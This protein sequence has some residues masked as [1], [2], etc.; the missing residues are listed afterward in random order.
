MAPLHRHAGPWQGPG[1][2][3]AGPPPMEIK[4]QRQALEQKRLSDMSFLSS[5]PAPSASHCDAAAFL[6]QL[7][8]GSNFSVVWQHAVQSSVHCAVQF[9]IVQC[10]VQCCVVCIVF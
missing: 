10:I 3:T 5:P 6:C 1:R 7:S 9:C 4:Y 2:A 8:F